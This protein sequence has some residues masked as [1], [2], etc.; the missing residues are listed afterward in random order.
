[1]VASFKKIETVVVNGAQKMQLLQLG[2]K[3][4]GIVQS[5]L[6]LSV[7]S[8]PCTTAAALSS[9]GVP[10]PLLLLLLSASPPRAMVAGGRAM[11]SAGSAP[12]L[13]KSR[14]VLTLM[15]PMLPCV[16]LRTLHQLGTSE[17]RRAPLRE[18]K[19]EGPMVPVELEPRRP[20]AG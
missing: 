8:A 13:P 6:K 3:Q 5:C 19:R 16:L 12:K 10:L 14:R 18:L 11:A 7:T 4:Y 9:R 1:M 15:L 20:L 2:V 17:A